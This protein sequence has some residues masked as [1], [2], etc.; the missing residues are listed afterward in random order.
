MNNIQLYLQLNM[1]TSQCLIWYSRIT[2]AMK[3]PIIFCDKYQNSLNINIYL[4]YKQISVHQT[5]SMVTVHAH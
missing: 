2:I 4:L 3:K 5:L 1:L